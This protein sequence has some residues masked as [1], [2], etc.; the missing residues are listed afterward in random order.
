MANLPCELL[1]FFVC[2]KNIQFLP[3]ITAVITPR[4]GNGDGKHAARQK[5]WFWGTNKL[6]QLPS[7]ENPRGFVVNPF[8]LT[9]TTS[10]GPSLWGETITYEHAGRLFQRPLQDK[11]DCNDPSLLIV[12][13]YERPASQVLR[14][15]K[16]GYP[17]CGIWSNYCRKS[18]A[19]NE[20]TS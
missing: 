11:G 1:C 7:W 10:V 16:S 4:L 5:S 6:S 13:I 14:R 19:L 2:V 15:L 3:G 20:T 8:V 17:W 9:T 12:R 18:P